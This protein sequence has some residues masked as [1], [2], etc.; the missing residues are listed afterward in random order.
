MQN[1]TDLAVN[2]AAPPSGSRR[3]GVIAVIATFG[4]LLFGYDTGVIN[5]A[6]A[7]LRAQLG[8]TTFTEGLVTSILLVGA[9]IGAAIGGQLSDRFGRRHNILLLAI[10]FALGTLGCVLA[11]HWGVL[12]VFRFVLGLAVGGAS[13]TVPVYLAEIAPVERR[14]SLVT[15]N[16]LAIVSGQFAAFAINALIYSIWGTTVMVGGVEVY[17]H[18]NIW[19]WMLVIAVLPAFALFFG[20]LRMPESPRWLFEHGREDEALAVLRQVRSPER[21][22][23]EIDEV[24]ELVQEEREHKIVRWS[25]LNVGW[26][27]RLI[28]VGIGIA[29]IQQLTGINSVM[30][31]GTA[32]LEKAGFAADVAIVANTANGIIAVVG[33]L[34]GMSIMNR[35]NRRTMLL[36][37]FIGTTAAHVL[38]GLSAKLVPDGA[39]YKPVLIMIFVVLFVFIMQATAGPLAWLML[40]EMFPLRF[41]GFAYGISGF[42]G[43]MTNFLVTLFFPSLIAGVGIANTYFIF[44]GL[45]VAAMVF[46]VKM[47]PETRGKTLERIEEDMIA[48]HYR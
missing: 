17:Q 4:G 25:A 2:T 31:Y 33:C 27:R 47:V 1:Q 48:G 6:L 7:P 23:S 42:M 28:L 12:A 34:F 46:I 24:R 5:G 21:A 29:M 15:R 30:Y 37:G 19:R 13:A 3:L 45:G 14:G 39:S 16:E 38:I 26:M 44:A 9:A 43:W 32:L 36:A 8:L 10:V 11:P 40:S 41:R 22:Q 18:P 20:M 35:V